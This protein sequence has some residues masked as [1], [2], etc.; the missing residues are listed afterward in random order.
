MSSAETWY[1][2]VSK[3]ANTHTAHSHSNHNTEHA[4]QDDE[5]YI[6]MEEGRFSNSKSDSAKTSSANPTSCCSSLFSSCLQQQ[7]ANQEAHDME[8]GNAGYTGERIET[9]NAD[10]RE[11]PNR[12]TST[13]CDMV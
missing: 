5:L 11:N 3:Q 7:K 6:Q 8:S 4:S 9:Y 12:K 2:N 1:G 13:T 10:N